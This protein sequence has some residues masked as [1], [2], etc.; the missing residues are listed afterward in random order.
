LFDAVAAVAGIRARVNHE[1]Q[2]AAELE[3]IAHLDERS[4]YPFPPLPT[5][6]RGALILDAR[7]TINAVVEDLEAGTAVEAVAARFHNALAE[8]TATACTVTAERRGVSVVVLSG[9][10]FQNR[11]LLERTTAAL[12]AVGLRVLVPERL[13]PNDGGISYGQAAVAAAQT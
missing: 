7:E 9:G 13:P 11:L 3:G 8:A 1:G 12:R 4:A 5:G 2:A 10:V 6:E